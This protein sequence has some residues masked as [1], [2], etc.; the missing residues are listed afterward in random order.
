MEDKDKGSAEVV[1]RKEG[2]YWVKIG[3]DW[4]IGEYHISG[5]GHNKW[6]SLFTDETG[7]WSNNNDFN[8]I[9]ERRICRS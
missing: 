6:W 5:S 8:E 7:C 1:D 2:Y 9:D 4:T 3:N